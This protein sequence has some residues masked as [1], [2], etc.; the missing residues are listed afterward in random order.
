MNA[1]NVRRKGLLP[2]ALNKPKVLV[3]VM[4]FTDVKLGRFECTYKILRKIK[5]PYS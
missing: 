1:L 5:A 4:C 3:D 2:L